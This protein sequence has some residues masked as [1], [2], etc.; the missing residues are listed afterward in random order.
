[1]STWP[2][3][4]PLVVQVNA[5]VSNGTNFATLIRGLGNSIYLPVMQR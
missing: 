1:M 2:V 5:Y 4:R 3:P